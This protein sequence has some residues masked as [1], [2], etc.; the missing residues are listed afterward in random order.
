MRQFAIES[1]IYRMSLAQTKKGQSSETLRFGVLYGADDDRHSYIGHGCLVGSRR[2]HVEIEFWLNISVNEQAKF[3]PKIDIDVKSPGAN[4]ASMAKIRMSIVISIVK[5]PK[6][7][8]FRVFT[9][10]VCA[11]LYSILSRTA[12]YASSNRKQKR[13]VTLPL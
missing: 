7:Q 1:D 11:S 12:S 9:F 10:L 13:I 5:N 2:R 4:E 8:S 3:T 6:T